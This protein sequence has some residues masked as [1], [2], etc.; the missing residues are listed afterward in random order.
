MIPICLRELEKLLR[1]NNILTMAELE[2]FILSKTTVLF[3]IIV[4]VLFKIL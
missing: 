2:D 3:D 1:K 4:V